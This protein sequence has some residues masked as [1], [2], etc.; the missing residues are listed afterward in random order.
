[1]RGGWWVARHG[2]IPRRGRQI[3]LQNILLLLPSPLLRR[4]RPRPG[5]NHNFQQRLHDSTVSQTHLLS[6]PCATESLPAKK[7]IKR[8]KLNRL[9]EQDPQRSTKSSVLHSRLPRVTRI[10][11]QTRL[12]SVTHTSLQHIC[13]VWNP[14][15]QATQ[16]R[17][18]VLASSQHPPPTLFPVSIQIHHT[19]FSA[20]TYVSQCSRLKA[21]LPVTGI[22]ALQKIPLQKL[23]FTMKL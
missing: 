19:F 12:P 14:S 23:P 6:T 4:L 8:K 18:D 13:H 17:Q 1:M 10:P 5:L 9:R 21:S 7:P 16:S 15:S 20:P 11:T 3:A 2:R 22:F